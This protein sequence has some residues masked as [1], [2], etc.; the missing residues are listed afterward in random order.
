MQYNPDAQQISNDKIT[1]TSD[2]HVEDIRKSEVQ[3][4][5]AYIRGE[6]R[7]GILAIFDNASS[8]TL[9]LR[10]LIENGTVRAKYTND[11]QLA[12]GTGNISKSADVAEVVL[13]RTDGKTIKVHA[14]VV[15]NIMDTEIK[16]KYSIEQV[17]QQSVEKLKKISGYEGIR[18]ENFQQV[19]GG[20]VEILIGQNEA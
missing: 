1:L 3:F 11:R 17:T 10:E 18:K 6:N 14:L 12:K 9:I 19:L 16:S 5:F 13:T 15:D 20:R 4:D 7:C 2:Y 8:T